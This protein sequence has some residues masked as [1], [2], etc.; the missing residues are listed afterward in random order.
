MSHALVETPTFTASVVVPDDGDLENAASVNGA[1]QAL[2]NRSER[3]KFST[4]GAIN[5]SGYNVPLT[6]FRPDQGVLSNND[7]WRY[8]FNGLLEH[9]KSAGNKAIAQLEL[10]EGAT[11]TQVQLLATGN[12]LAGAAHGALPATMPKVTFRELATTGGTNYSVNQSDTSGNVGAYEIA[13]TITLTV[14]RVVSNLLRYTIEIEGEQGANS[15]NDY[16]GVIN[17]SISW[18]VVP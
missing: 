8:A 12:F 2:A 13:H 3:L 10:P 1:L 15:I 6:K 17:C 16:F 4:F 9:D 7:A 11:I 5:F 18:T 14:N